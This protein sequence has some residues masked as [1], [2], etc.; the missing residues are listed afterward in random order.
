RR[1]LAHAGGKAGCLAL[2]TLHFPG[3]AAH[4]L[5][6]FFLCRQQ[7]GRSRLNCV[8]DRAEVRGHTFLRA[9]KNPA[10]GGVIGLPYF[11]Y[12]ECTSFAMARASAKPNKSISVS[13]LL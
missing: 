2:S 6:Y 10:L 13:L 4:G 1:Q 11:V 3:H 9:I 7:G 5:V 12:L 8:I